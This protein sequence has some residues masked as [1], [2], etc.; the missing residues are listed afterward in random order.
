MHDFINFF[1]TYCF[2]VLV[3]SRKEHPEFITYEFLKNFRGLI[4]VWCGI[5][6]CGKL[7]T[8]FGWF[9]YDLKLL[10]RLLNIGDTA[11]SIQTISHFILF[12]WFW[13]G[14]YNIE[15]II[16]ICWRGTA[17]Y[18]FSFRPSSCWILNRRMLIIVIII[19]WLTNIIFEEGSI[20]C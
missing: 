2:I 5:I 15:S 8:Q 7:W 10:D 16:R 3:R 20:G 17:Q 14:S 18:L 12:I 19:F 13:G 6:Y 11:Y 9:I 4:N 1:S